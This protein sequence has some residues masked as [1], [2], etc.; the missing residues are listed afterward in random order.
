MVATDPV[1]TNPAQITRFPIKWRVVGVNQLGRIAVKSLR[2]QFTRRG[3]AVSQQT[4]SRVQMSLTT[5]IFAVFL[6]FV[7]IA[8]A[9]ALMRLFD[10]QDAT[11]E[12]TQSEVEKLLTQANRDV[13]IRRR[14]RAG[15][16]SNA[17]LA[18]FSHFAS[19]SE[20]RM[21]FQYLEQIPIER[22]TLQ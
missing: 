14:V 10:V 22:P 17:A 1:I 4:E 21:R 11:S 18:D 3:F 8:V 16:P 19:L 5:V 12:Q 2:P 6:P 20:T 15:A 9:T 7:C 13:K